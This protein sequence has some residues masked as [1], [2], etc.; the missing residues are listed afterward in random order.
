VDP[1]NLPLPIYV[2]VMMLGIVSAVNGGRIALHRRVR[3]P[4]VELRGALAISL[5]L[6][7]LVVGLAAVVFAWVKG[8]RLDQ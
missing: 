2:G 7:L 4:L 8:L 5:G 3:L 6:V 1:T